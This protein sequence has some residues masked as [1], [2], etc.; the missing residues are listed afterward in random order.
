MFKEFAIFLKE[1]N[2]VS[3][4][5][6]FVMGTASTALVNS[7]VKDILMPVAEPLLSAGPWR[8]AALDIGP[9]SIAYGS[10]IAELFNFVILALIIFLIAK[11]LLKMEVPVKK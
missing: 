3:L 4:A 8:E 7:L 6:G 1:F 10:F 2:V 5:V 9:I 11:K